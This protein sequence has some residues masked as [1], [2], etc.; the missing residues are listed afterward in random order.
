L[1]VNSAVEKSEG[2]L[3]VREEL[4]RI[5]TSMALNGGGGGGGKRRK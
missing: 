2:L 4:E 1:A 3:V 5:K